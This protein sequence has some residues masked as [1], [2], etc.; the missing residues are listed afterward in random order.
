MQHSFQRIYL[1]R[2]CVVLKQAWYSVKH[3]CDV[4]CLFIVRF[5]ADGMLHNSCKIQNILV[6]WKYFC[7][8]VAF[9]K[10]CSI[11]IVDKEA[12]VAQYM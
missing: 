1:K 11:I 4:V 12:V 8:V 5:I 2:V 3:I 7:S 6:V 10:C 9:V